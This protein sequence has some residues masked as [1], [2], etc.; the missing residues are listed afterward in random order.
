MSEDSKESLST[1]WNAPAR[2]AVSITANDSTDLVNVSRGL[3]VGSSGDIAVILADDTAVVVIVG[4]GAGSILPLR[5][6]RLRS[7]DTTASDI[8]ALY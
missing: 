4:V 8:V 1:G 3:Y 2:R 7:T 5:V 6:K